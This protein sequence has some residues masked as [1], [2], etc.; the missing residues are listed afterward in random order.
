M[1]D[2]F[3]CK[4]RKTP[5]FQNTKIPIFCMFINS[6]ILLTNSRREFLSSCVA[7]ESEAQ[8]MK[9]FSPDWIEVSLSPWLLFKALLQKTACHAEIC[10]I[11]VMFRG[12]SYFVTTKAL[13]I[14]GLGFFAP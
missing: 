2:S 10:E 11:C 9:K 4:Q 7:I 12:G 5:V 1:G 14:T 13:S 6:P 8:K 3:E